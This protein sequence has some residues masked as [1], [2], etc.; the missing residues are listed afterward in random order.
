MNLFFVSHRFRRLNFPGALL[1]A[2]LQ[3]TPA[4]RVVAQAETVLV[5]SPVASVLRSVLSAVA[6]LGAIQSMAGAT[7]LVAKSGQ[8][9]VS[10]GFTTTVGTTVSVFFTVLNTQTPPASWRVSGTFPPGLN[11]SGLTSTGIVNV[12]DLNMTGTPTTAGTYQV[13]ITAYEG[14]NGSLISTEAYAYTVTVNG[15]TTGTAPAITTQPQSQTVNVGTAVSFTV[16]ASGTPAPTFQWKKDN[17]SIS[18]ATS[19]TL[20]LSNVQTTDAGAYTAVAANSAGS[21]TSN[22][23][24][25]TVT[26]TGTKATFSVMPSPQSVV[27]GDTVT[28][29]ATAAGS[30]TPT[31][32]WMKDGVAVAN[33]A[34]ISGA[35]SATLAIAG[36]TA[37]DAGSYTVVA[38]NTAGAAT[39]DAAVVT[40]NSAPISSTAAWMSNLSVRTTIVAGQNPLIVGLTVRGGAKNILVRG[41]GPALANFGLQG[42]L[43]DPQLQLFA[44]GAATAMLT[45]NDWDSSLAGTFTSVGAFGFTTGSKDAAFQQSL[46]GGYTVQLPA[47]GPGTVL[48][49]AYDM[50]P[51]S[52][53]PRLVNISAR[54]RVGTGNDVLI[55]GF[56]IVGSGTK[57]LLIRAVGPRLSEFGVSGTLVDPKL[58]VYTSDNVKIAENDN[59][60]ASLATTFDSVGAFP[61]TVGSKDAAMIVPLASGHTYTVL[62]RGADGGTGE[63]LVEVYELP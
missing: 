32:Q 60:D 9:D 2:L 28:L 30:P 26:A 46:D 29:T 42:V 45:N 53:S 13:N 49:E 17:V 27:V 34:R 31:F 38:S 18:G 41:A 3:R 44:S 57:K 24:T 11:F 61:L 43:A 20:N 14:T 22:A 12:Q 58:E 48:V 59:W 40:V 63:A 37:A 25:L 19:A 54:N 5:G 23:A 52:N 62:A 4:L 36:V 21:V 35:T 16:A 15:G 47:T 50:S 10:T 51:S 1:L 39:S 7:P 8:T 55:E 56:A 6:S 33:S